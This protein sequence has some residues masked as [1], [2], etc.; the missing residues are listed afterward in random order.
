[1]EIKIKGLDR[2]QRMIERKAQDVAGQYSLEEVFPDDYV[3]SVSPFSS[4]SELLAASPEKILDADA[5]KQADQAT[6]DE[7]IS[8]QTPFENWQA[9]LT[10]ASEKLIA[11]K[12]RM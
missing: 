4:L 3:Q 2:F 1:M 6:L 10:D 11:K 8:Q 5:F 7:F 12:L 9:L